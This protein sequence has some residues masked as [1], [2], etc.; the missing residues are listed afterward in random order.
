MAK[1]YYSI[2]GV[3][4]SASDEDIKK[5]YRKLAHQHHPDKQGGDE[6]KFKEIN[7]AYQVLSN[8]EKRA[9]YDQFG[10][11]F[12]NA[13][14]SA[15]GFSGFGG[16]NPNDF[17]NW[18]FQG[19]FGGND[20]GDIFETI[21]EQ[22]GGEGKKRKT[23]H[24]GNDIETEDTLSLEEVFRGV[25]RVIKFKTH[26]ACVK[27]NGAGH[28][29]AKGFGTCTK[30]KGKG[31]LRVERRTMFGNFS[32]IAVCDE[33]NGSGKIPNAVCSACGGSGRVLDVKEIKFSVT[34]GIED[35][36]ILQVR[37]GGEVGERGARSGD[38]FVR[39]RVKPH[40][41]FSRKKDDLFMKKEISVTDALLSKKITA[42]DIGGEKF[43]FSVPEDFDMNEPLKIRGRGMLKFGSSSRG[44][45]YIKFSIKTP[46]KLS[47]KARESLEELEK[48]L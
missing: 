33:C 44:D 47:K 9:Q 11:T 35:G 4:R 32:Q 14:G 30:C 22:F 34:P 46:K 7:E 1:D 29:A 3:S 13:Q 24:R 40:A 21:F 39:I 19:G 15:G 5:A 43:Q 45:L 36:Q 23:D 42:E 10:T 31:E 25:D 48:E 41:V 6:K 37:G 18:N 12:D 28:D 2:L 8:K 17:Q 38:L 26:M 16:F 20:F 27:C